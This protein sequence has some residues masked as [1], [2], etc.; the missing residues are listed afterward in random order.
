ML[1]RFSNFEKAFWRTRPLEVLLL[2]AVSWAKIPNYTFTLNL[3]VDTKC[4]SISR[5]Q[6]QRW[7]HLHPPRRSHWMH[8]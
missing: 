1:V 7:I 2:P 3:N 5:S 4:L 6:T 8:S